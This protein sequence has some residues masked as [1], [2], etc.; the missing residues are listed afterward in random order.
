MG[1]IKIILGS[2]SCCDISIF[3]TLNAMLPVPILLVHS[4]NDNI[5]MFGLVCSY[6]WKYSWERCVSLFD[7][8]VIDELLRLKKCELF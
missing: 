1:Q 7:I 2:S 8:N 4:V 6:S 5:V 3:E